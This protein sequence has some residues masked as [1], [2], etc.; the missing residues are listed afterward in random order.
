[1]GLESACVNLMSSSPKQDASQPAQ[2]W[3]L[4]GGCSGC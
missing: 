3:V 2:L 4:K 1:M